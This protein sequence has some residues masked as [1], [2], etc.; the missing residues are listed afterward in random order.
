MT[1]RPKGVYRSL[2]FFVDER[3][4]RFTSES[5]T[6]NV[7]AMVGGFTPASNDARMRFAFL[8]GISAI[9]EGFDTGR[10]AGGAE[11]LLALPVDVPCSRLAISASTA[12][13]N[14]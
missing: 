3:M 13:C 1:L 12:A 5:D 14:Q 2:H 11:A 4:V 6:P 7:R 10:D 9:S 8:S